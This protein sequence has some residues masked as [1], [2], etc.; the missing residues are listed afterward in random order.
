MKAVLVKAPGDA[1]QLYIGDAPTPLVGDHEVLVKIQSFGLNRMDILQR[2][3]RYPPPPGV[4]EILGVEMAGVI[5]KVGPKVTL[6]AVGD[7]VCGLMKGGAYAEY[8]VIHEELAFAIPEGFTPQQAAAIPE[9]WITAY[10]ALHKVG[11]LKANQDVLIHAGASGVGLA[12]IQLAKL[13]GARN[14]CVT[15]GSDEKLRTCKEMGATVTIN[16][17][18]QRWLD[19]VMEHTQQRGVDMIIDFVC[20]DYWNDNLHAL[21]RDGHMVML[22]TLSGGKV[23]EGNLAPILAKRLRIQGSTLRS[24]S[25]EYQIELARDVRRDLLPLLAS[26]AL[27]VVID[28]EYPWSEIA[29][30]HRRMEKN[31]N[32]GKIV[33]NVE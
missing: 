14:I 21:A 20:A 29:E 18:T 10:Q 28:K 17:R 25:L 15:A 4:T 33:V 22:A 6:H 11:E 13:A 30:A 31:L 26:G 9:V 12:A 8:C 24:R 23:T 1:S 3:G 7:H 16:Y 32:V 5:E 19:V 2:E 27:R